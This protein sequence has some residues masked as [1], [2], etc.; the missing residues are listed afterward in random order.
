MMN[1]KFSSG[2]SQLIGRGI[3]Y[4][5]PI[6][7]DPA[8]H[9][10]AVVYGANGQMYLS[11][12]A[13]WLSFVDE[14]RFSELA[15][16]LTVDFI[17]PVEP[18]TVYTVRGN[19]GPDG[20]FTSLN[21]AAAFLL[22]RANTSIRNSPTVDIKILS[23]H[24][25]TEQ[26]LLSG[27]G[28]GWANLSSEDAEVFVDQ[29]FL[30]TASPFSGT[31]NPTYPLLG[32]YNS[33]GMQLDAVFRID[34]TLTR[35][36]V[37][38]D[39]RS[40]VLLSNEAEFESGVPI[41]NRGFSGFA[42]GMALG[43]GTTARFGGIVCKDYTD[44]GVICTGGATRVGFRTLH[45]P[46]IHGD[47]GN[48]LRAAIGALCQVDNNSD[49]RKGGS[50]TTEGT[51]STANQNADIRVSTGGKILLHSSVLGGLSRPS[52]F[53]TSAGSVI[54]RGG[55][56]N[57]SGG[58]SGSNANGNFT[59]FADG[60]QICWSNLSLTPTANSASSVPWT[61]PAAFS[62]SSSNVAISLS[63]HSGA[64]GSQLI[65]VSFSNPSVTGCDVVLFRT[66]SAL[67]FI[68]ATA[69]G[70]WY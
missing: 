35:R 30:T 41:F 56:T 6:P 33:F 47:A 53:V 25:M 5:V 10:G 14:A 22:G 2:R 9:E 63:C 28:L 39:A 65:E 8:P 52:G 57:W 51:F 29:D 19:G 37:G 23:G 31:S 69:I 46:T 3:V 62:G 44:H 21:E 32:F 45:T 24:V 58:V 68:R 60:T 12:G 15:A 16:D 70:R 36:A 54:Y 20:D 49:L 40:S 66:N 48:G 7:L 26:L 50:A 11:D 64:P 61:F 4:P 43:S 38:L 17:R 27:I 34:E 42:I 13:E 18:D 1:R 59:R 55:D 67:T